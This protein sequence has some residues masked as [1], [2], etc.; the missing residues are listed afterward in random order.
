MLLFMLDG[1]GKKCRP[2]NKPFATIIIPTYNQ[3]AF[4]AQALESVLSQTDAD[5]EAI[6]V[7]DGVTNGSAEVAESYVRRDGRIRCINKPNG[8]VASALNVGLTNAR[9]D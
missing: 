3:E 4:L 8:G 7:N 9:G 1:H 2:M 5:W 6:I